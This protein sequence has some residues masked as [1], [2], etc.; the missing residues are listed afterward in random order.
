MTRIPANTKNRRFILTMIIFLF[1]S[2]S[3]NLFSQELNIIV[4]LEGSWKFS[5]GDDPAWATVKCDDSDWDY[6]T[7]PRSWENNGFADYNGFAWYR[8]AFTVPADYF[9]FE[10]PILALGTIDDVDEV[11]LNGQLVGSSG[12]MPPMV[13]TAFRMQRRYPIPAGLIKANEENVIAVRVFDD[14]GVGG[15]Y[16]GPVGIFT[17]ADND[18]LLMNLSGYWDFEPFIKKGNNNTQPDGKIFVPGYWENAGYPDLDGTATYSRTF[19]TPK[20][21]DE[22]HLMIVLGYIDDL[23]KVYINGVRIGEQEQREQNYNA[24]KHKDVIFRG[25]KIPPGTL[26]SSGT[27]LIEVRVTD[28]GGLGGIYKGPV[29]LLSEKNFELIKKSEMGKNWNIWDNFLKDFFE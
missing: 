10:A 12:Q 29:G 20:N 25:Y 22:E 16:D 7:V 26:K 1:I 19:E 14:F 9:D 5:I 28:T 27:N 21:V 4:D 8:K 3:V 11:Y 2:S 24:E 23:D 15:I 13:V 18:M 17:Y 6:L